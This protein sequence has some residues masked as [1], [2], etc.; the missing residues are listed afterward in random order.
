MDCYFKQE[1]LNKKYYSTIKEFWKDL[2]KSERKKLIKRTNS[3][4]SEVS[5]EKYAKMTWKKI[6][7]DRI[8]EGAGNLSG[9]VNFKRSKYND[10]GEL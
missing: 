9:F 5:L 3:E 2:P 8:N 1:I 10:S 7:E 4:M 6:S